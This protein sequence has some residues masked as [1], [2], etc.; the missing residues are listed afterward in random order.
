MQKIKN[1]GKSIL[2]GIYFPW[3][4][5]AASSKIN[6]TRD[7]ADT[8]ETVY[9]WTEEFRV[10]PKLRGF[11]INFRSSQVKS[12]ILGLLLELKKNPPKVILEIGTATAGTLFMFAR[13]AAPDA[14]IISIDLPF[15]QIRRWLFKI[16]NSFTAK[17]CQLETENAS[18]ALQLP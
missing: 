5:P 16:S 12:E 4:V 8:P 6:K 15:W 10:G 9:N 18:N 13:V 7:E 11:N 3:L 1:F 17:F 14:Q 2:A